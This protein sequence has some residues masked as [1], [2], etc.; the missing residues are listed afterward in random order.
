MF[1][2]SYADSSYR[3]ENTNIGGQGDMSAAQLG[4]MNISNG[5]GNGAGNGAA[6]TAGD[7]PSGV[8][9]SFTWPGWFTGVNA[10]LTLTFLI[11][12]TALVMGVLAYVEVQN[13]KKSICC[14]K[15]DLRAVTNLADYDLA[16][17]G[18]WSAVH[19]GILGGISTGMLFAAATSQ[20]VSP[21]LTSGQSAA[22]SVILAPY[23]GTITALQFQVN[24]VPTA[25]AGT[26]T[27]YINGSATDLVG[28]YGSTSSS[29]DLVQTIKAECLCSCPINFSECDLIGIVFTTSATYT[30]AASTPLTPTAQLV[31]KYNRT[32]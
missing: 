24:A 16:E 20:A 13:A 29:A 18:G 15:T 1:P 11:A 7:G 17:I 4:S 3:M 21:V 32:S 14:L 26:F 10:M 25:G 30:N 5:N 23:C 28:T 31:V 9:A 19:S 8:G 2:D 12:V 27:V 6:R 22:S